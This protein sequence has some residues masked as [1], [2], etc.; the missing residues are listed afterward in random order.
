M[1]TVPWPFFIPFGAILLAAMFLSA[2]VESSRPENTSTPKLRAMNV[3]LGLLLA[4]VGFLIWFFDI[5]TWR[6]RPPWNRPFGF[7]LMCIGIIFSAG[8]MLM[9]RA[10]LVR[11][12]QLHTRPIWEQDYSGEPDITPEQRVSKSRFR[13]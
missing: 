9:S 13:E 4:Y 3:A 10:G 6:L 11:D 8:V 7:G 5:E 2:D 12:T 1:A